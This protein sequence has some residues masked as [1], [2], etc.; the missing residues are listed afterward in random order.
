MARFWQIVLAGSM[1]VLLLSACD[2]KISERGKQQLVEAAEQITPDETT[3]AEVIELLG[4]PSAVG[5]FADKAWYYV[6]QRK[7]GVGF[8]APEVVDS[9]VLRLTFS[10]DT[11]DDV[12]NYDQSD[13]RQV[14]FSDRATPTEGQEYGFIEQLIGNIGKF[15]KQGADSVQ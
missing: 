8:F 9:H 13:T 3:R 6:A 5:Q 11:V 14:S 10:G 1:A 7:E 4:T 2:P 15:N 12:R